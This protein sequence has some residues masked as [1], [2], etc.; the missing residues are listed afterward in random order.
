MHMGTYLVCPDGRDRCVVVARPRHRS[1]ALNL[2]IQGTLESGGSPLSTHRQGWTRQLLEVVAGALLATH[3]GQVRQ[4]TS[5][6]NLR[7]EKKPGKRKVKRLCI[8]QVTLKSHSTTLLVPAGGNPRENSREVQACR[9]PGACAGGQTARHLLPS[10]QQPPSRRQLPQP[11][12][13]ATVLLHSSEHAQAQPR[14]V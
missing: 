11:A 13:A 9:H 14:V 6:A 12:E 7:L 1:L 5:Q 10:C 8:L 2:H 4:H 3:R